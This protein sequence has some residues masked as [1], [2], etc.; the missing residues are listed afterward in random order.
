MFAARVRASLLLAFDVPRGYVGNQPQHRVLK[1][2]P[3]GGVTTADPAFLDLLS[4]RVGIILAIPGNKARGAVPTVNLQGA[5]LIRLPREWQ[6]SLRLCACSFRQGSGSRSASAET[7]ADC[8]GEQPRTDPHR[9]VLPSR[10]ESGKARME[11]AAK[12]PHSG[13]ASRKA[14][15]QAASMLDRRARFRRGLEIFD[16]RLDETIDCYEF[17]RVVVAICLCLSIKRVRHALAERVENRG[18][19][20]RVFKKSFL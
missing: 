14:S 9:W 6:I 1:N 18:A 19:V 10:S 20:H 8:S 7:L 2:V 11:N 3:L 5:F 4:Q 17:R 15:G 16:D 12:R 13:V